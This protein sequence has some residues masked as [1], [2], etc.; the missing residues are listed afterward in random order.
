METKQLNNLE[1]TQN[2]DGDFVLTQ[3]NFIDEI[4]QPIRITPDMLGILIKWLQELEQPKPQK[5]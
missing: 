3:Y 4:Y 2:I 1:L 5:D